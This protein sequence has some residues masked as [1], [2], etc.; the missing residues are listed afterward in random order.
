MNLSHY[1]NYQDIKT[2]FKWEIPEA[3]NIA[4]EA[5]SRWAEHRGRVAIFYEDAAGYRETWTFWQLERLT[6]RLANLLRELGIEAGDRVGI[7]L[8][9]VP[10]T[11]AAHLAIYKLGAIAVPMSM[12]YGS[13]SYTYILT[14]CAAKAVIV[15]SA[16][17]G[18]LRA[19]RAKLPSLEHL[20]VRGEAQAGEVAL[21]PA[22]TRMPVHFETVPTKSSDPA[23]LLYTSGTTGHPK[24]ALHAH[25]ILEGY[26]LTV[27]LF[28]NID[29]DAST[30]FWTPSDWAW[31]GGLL[32][33]LLPALALGRPVLAYNGRFQV[34]TAYELMSRYGVTHVFLAPTALKMLAQ[35][36]RPKETYDL[37]IRVIASGGESVADEV[38]RW[39]ER[40]LGA[41]CNEFYGLTEVNHLAGSCAR[42]W[43]IRPGSMGKPYPGREVELLDDEGRSVPPGTIGQI[44]VRPGDPTMM[45]EYWKKPEATADRQRWGWVLTGDLAYRDEEGYIFFKGRNDDMISSGGYRIGP[46]EVEEV[47]L[48]HPAVAEAAVVGS[49]DPVR[50]Q[51]VKA[52]ITLAEDYSGGEALVTELQQLVREQLAAYKYPREVTFVDHLPTTTTGKLNRRQLRLLEE[53]AK[54]GSQG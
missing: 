34:D 25:R 26:L 53:E 5:L 28:F 46:A 52:F 37:D 22:L 3:Y 4:T 51:I 19:V 9:Q 1:S 29:F 49:P 24:G 35:V 8:P 12:L 11:A 30:L 45:L 15:D 33:I 41:V 2:N 31:V 21:G 18:K 48:R 7:V 14:D 42:L 39:T 38:L 10:E 17:A 32:D 6:N 44:A 54:G 50:G 47:L 40:E 13:E 16:Y 27:Q 20:I 23:L 43:P 36:S